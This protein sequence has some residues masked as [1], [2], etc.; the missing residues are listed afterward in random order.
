MNKPLRGKAARSRA[1]A[2]K[3]RMSRRC[4]TCLSTC[5]AGSGQLSTEAQAAGVKDEDIDLFTCEAL[6]VTLTNVN[7]DPEAITAYIKKQRTYQ[8]QLR[9]RL[10]A[11]KAKVNSPFNLQA[12]KNH[13]WPDRSRE[14]N[15]GIN[16]D[17]TVDADLHSLQW[18]LTYGLK[19]SRRLRVPCR[20]A[21]QKRRQSFRLHQPGTSRS[22]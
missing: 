4:K 16:S 10:Y 21:R 1:S 9:S 3:T 17:P 22:A 11:V 15:I 6:F 5:S 20:A 7:F 8:E 19:G 12:G 18:L 14:N 13:R 2:E